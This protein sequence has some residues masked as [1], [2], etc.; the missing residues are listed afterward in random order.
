[1]ELRSLRE[2]VFLGRMGQ[3]M[4]VILTSADFLA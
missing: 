3:E 2:S 4:T 1:V